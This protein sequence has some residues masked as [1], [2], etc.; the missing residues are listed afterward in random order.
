MSSSLLL[1]LPELLFSPTDCFSTAS[2]FCHRGPALGG[3]DALREKHGAA[4]LG[5]TQ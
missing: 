5:H 4:P 3:N 2:V 1:L